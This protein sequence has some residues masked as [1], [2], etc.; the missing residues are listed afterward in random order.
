[1]NDLQNLIGLAGRLV[2]KL[3]KSLIARL[4]GS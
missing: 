3:E 2:N 1:M 4:A